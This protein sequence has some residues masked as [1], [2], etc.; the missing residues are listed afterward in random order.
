MSDTTTPRAHHPAKCPKCA[1]PVLIYSDATT[2]I[3]SV[4]QHLR[5][6]YPTGAVASGP[7]VEGGTVYI[8]GLN[9]IVYALDAATGH[10]RWADTIADGNAPVSDLAVAGGTVCIASLDYNVYALDAATGNIRWTYT[11]AGPV[12]ASGPAVA[13]GTVY[14]GS[15]DNVYALSA[16]GS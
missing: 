8:G 11:T 14:V 12:P 6:T 15:Y 7:A 4:R 2:L 10:F 3:L 13:N 5:W 9:G 1:H 16:A